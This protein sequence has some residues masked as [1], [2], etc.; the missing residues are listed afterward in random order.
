[1]TINPILLCLDGSKCGRFCVQ[2]WVFWVT[3][4]RFKFALLLYQI[5]SWNDNDKPR[6]KKALT[7]TLQFELRKRL[8]L[9]DHQIISY[10]I[11]FHCISSVPRP[12]LVAIHYLVN[13]LIINMSLTTGQCRNYNGPDKLIII[14]FLK[15]FIQNAEKQ[16]IKHLG[17]T[18]LFMI[19]V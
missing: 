5:V 16:P 9:S 18:K 1:M 15:F 6:E 11:N 14:A 17:L 12:N 8:S 4:H 13:W 7:C 19:A 2:R 10:N 3:V